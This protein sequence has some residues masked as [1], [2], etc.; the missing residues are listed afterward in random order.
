M[1]L[2]IYIRDIHSAVH[3][4]DPGK[5]CLVLNGHEHSAHDYRYSIIRLQY[6]GRGDSYIVAEF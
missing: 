2:A 1:L 4:P 3:Q 5:Q 6:M